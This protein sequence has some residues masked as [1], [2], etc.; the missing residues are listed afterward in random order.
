M[1]RQEVKLQNAAR[2]WRWSERLERLIADPAAAAD[3][4]PSLRMSLGHYLASREARE[5][6]G[7]PIEPPGEVRH[8]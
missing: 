3:I 5:A 4:S 7:L 8:G 2:T 6:L 1:T